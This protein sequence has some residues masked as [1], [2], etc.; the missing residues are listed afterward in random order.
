MTFGTAYDRAVV[1]EIKQVLGIDLAYETMSGDYFTR[2]EDDPPELWSMGWVADYP[3]PNDFLGILLGTGSSN[4]YGGWS[5]S[6]F[7]TAIADAL[8]T[9]DPGAARAAFD[10]AEAI[11]R[12]EAP[13]IPLTYDVE[14][15]LAREG[16]LGASENGLGITRMAGLAWSSP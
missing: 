6:T 11:V 14:W 15:R 10:R 4:N 1:A 7:D 9:T 16:L 3:A 12:D 8:A 2:L 5:S 13:V